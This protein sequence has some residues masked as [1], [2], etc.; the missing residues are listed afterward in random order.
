[1]LPDNKINQTEEQSSKRNRSRFHP[2]EDKVLMQLV[3]K[4]GIERWETIARNIPGK[5]ARQCR[6][7]WYGH[8]SP[9]ALKQ[10]WTREDDKLLIQKVNEFGKKWVK[11]SSFFLNRTDISLKNRFNQLMRKKSKSEKLSSVQNKNSQT[12]VQQQIIFPKDLFEFEENQF[13]WIEF[14]SNIKLF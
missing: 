5:S 2:E 4:Y 8:V 14:A 6:E 11:I 1:M 3:I 9:F 7:R 10:A 12:E 13:E